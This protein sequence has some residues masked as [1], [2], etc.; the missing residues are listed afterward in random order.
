M[1]EDNC[2]NIGLWA[3]NPGSRRAKSHC[4]VLY[5]AYDRDWGSI[6]L[7]R[8]GHT[9]QPI[10]T[11]PAT[12]AAIEI[13]NTV[14]RAKSFQYSGRGKQDAAGFEADL[15]T[16]GMDEKTVR[17]FLD[18][19]LP[20]WPDRISYQLETLDLVRMGPIHPE[21]CYFSVEGGGSTYGDSAEM[22]TGK[23]YRL[24]DAKVA[25]TRDP[26]VAIQLIRETLR[27]PSLD[28]EARQRLQEAREAA[29]DRGGI[30]YLLFDETPMSNA[31]RALGWDAVRVVENDDLPG[32]ATSIFALYPQ[33]VRNRVK[34]AV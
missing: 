20:H 10:A 33:M 7:E 18:A 1:S 3:T 27:N 11:A 12:P 6:Q 9:G 8:N 28:Q 19:A 26:E 13:R 29:W 14:F 25:D 22:G 21:G 31:A 30:G 34:L 17:R 15:R 2:W 32:E 4:L 16:L 23:R 24:S 5:L